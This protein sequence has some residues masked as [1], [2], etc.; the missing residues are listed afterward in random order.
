MSRSSARRGQLEPIPATVAVL[1]VVTGLTLY[2][3]VL[4]DALPGSRDR[5]VATHVLDD[6]ERAASVGGVLRPDR[7]GDAT[8]VAPDGY[9]CNVTLA[10][11]GTRWR[12]GPP[13]GGET[14]AAS[15]LVSVR[16]GPGVVRRGRLEVTL[17]R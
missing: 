1:V 9:E 4:E 11:D 5:D 15:R 13:P 7:L 8:A 17:W 10:V 3:G 2:V 16:L 12:R 14:D 6:V